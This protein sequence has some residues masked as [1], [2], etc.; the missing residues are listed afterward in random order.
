MLHT[1]TRASGYPPLDDP[2]PVTPYRVIYE[3]GKASVRH[4]AAVGQARETPIVLV[5]ALIKRPFILDLQRGNS[6]IE[7]LT[8]QGFDVFLIDWLPPTSADSWRGFDAYVNQ[9]LANAVRAVQIH[10]GVE[11]VSVM[12]YCLGA[13]LSV[14]Y[15]A[16]HCRNI[17]NLVTLALPLDMS[18]REL[19]AY[20][21]I[22]WLDESAI[23]WL[24]TTYGNCPAW[25]LKNL[26]L[27]TTSAYRVGAYFGLNPESERD[28][29]ARCLPTFRRWLES[30]VPLAGQL[31]RELAVDV[32]KQNRLMHGRMT[33]GGEIV[34]LRHITAPLLN[35]VASQD[36][37]V[38]PKS[39]RPLLEAVA[40]D[41]K[42]NLIFPTGHLGAVVSDQAHAKLWPEI[43][44]WLGQ[45]DR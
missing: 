40:S 8:R 44:A 25:W 14:I 17:K 29:Y 27:M 5:Y 39:S 6:V 32:F 2:S 34:D 15:A 38:D 3:G 37:L 23:D 22:D 42:A 20:Q 43:G 26:F 30:E 1:L 10:Q 7:S 18:A 11:Q 35:V 36:V 31:V 21:P 41:D 9:D 12:G 24:I 33:I 28:R 13:L 19:P 45:R 16:L 4:Y